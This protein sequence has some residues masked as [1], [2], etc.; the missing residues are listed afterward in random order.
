MKRCRIWAFLLFSQVGLESIED[1]T[2]QNNLKGRSRFMSKKGWT[3]SQGR[4]GKV[5]TRSPLTMPIDDVALM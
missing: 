4:K 2:I 3:D 5:R 1:P